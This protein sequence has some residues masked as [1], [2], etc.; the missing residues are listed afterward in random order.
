MTGG[1]GLDVGLVDLRPLPSLATL[2][3]GV[4]G[5]TGL[6][7]YYRLVLVRRLVSWAPLLLWSCAG[8]AASAWLA[9]SY[10]VWYFGAFGVDP[11]TFLPQPLPLLTFAVGWGMFLSAV[12][13]HATRWTGAGPFAAIQPVSEAAPAPAASPDLPPV[14]GRV[15]GVGV[16]LACCLLAAGAGVARERA[17]W[18]RGDDHAGPELGMLSAR[19]AAGAGVH[20]AEP[21]I[22]VK[23]GSRGTLR[24]RCGDW[25][26]ARSD[27]STA[28]R[29]VWDSV[30][31]SAARR[32]TPPASPRQ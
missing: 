19:L 17:A 9:R 13:W 26:P 11:S 12:V 31:S 7:L 21:L 6:W 1:L 28:L 32:A 4:V 10:L 30:T 16:L 23:A 25:W 22:A 24:W 2:A 27:T 8:A 18:V 29:Q 5:I 3:G 20:C 14:G 15:F